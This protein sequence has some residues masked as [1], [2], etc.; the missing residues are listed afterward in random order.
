MRTST[1]PHRFPM[2]LLATMAL[3]PVAQA[4]T[5]LELL[6]DYS[7]LAG[8]P[9][10]PERGQRLFTTEGK[11]E[12]NLSCASCHGSVPTKTGKHALS[13]KAIP[14]LAPAFNPESFT[15]KSK[16][17][18]WFRLNCMEVLGRDCNAAEKADVLSWLL[19]F[20]R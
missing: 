14:P 2:L 12:L 1:H 19:S 9:P 15:D 17:D 10:L 7:K 6:A 13:E 20:K 16:A 3:A 4:A 11:S 18:R 5:P 8:S